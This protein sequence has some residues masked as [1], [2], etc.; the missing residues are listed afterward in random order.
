V[1]SAR[2]TAHQALLQ[3]P[4]RFTA[5][6]H[7]RGIFTEEEGRFVAV[8]GQRRLQATSIAQACR[9]QA[10]RPIWCLPTIGD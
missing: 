5:T 2:G 8:V 6:R 10:G 4:R 7:G 9:L 1:V 3:Q